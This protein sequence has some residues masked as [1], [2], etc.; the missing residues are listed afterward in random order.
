MKNMWFKKI[1]AVING[2]KKF[3]SLGADWAERLCDLGIDG[4]LLLMFFGLPIFFVG[5]TFQGIAFEKEVYFYFIVLLSLVFWALKS[6]ISGEMKIRKSP[7]DIPLIAFII[8]VFISTVLSVDKWHSFLGSFVDPSRGLVGLMAL[9]VAFYLIFERTRGKKATV[10]IGALI[11]SNF[12]LS[13]WTATQIMDLH[14]P[15]GFLSSIPLNLSDS[16]TDLVSFFS[17]MLPVLVGVFIKANGYQKNRLR[18]IFLLSFLGLSVVLDLFLVFAFYAFLSLAGWIALIVGLAFF[19]IFIISKV[20]R[21]EKQSLIWLPALIFALL[22]ILFAGGKPVNIAR[23]NL[24]AEVSLNYQASKE[25]AKGALGEKLFFGSGPATY[26]YVASRFHPKNLNLNAVY[27][28]RFSQGTGF[29]FESLAT[30]GTLGTVF[31]IVLI[32]SFFGIGTYLITSGKDSDKMYPLALFSAAIVFLGNLLF[33]RTGGPLIISGALIS[34]LAMATMARDGRTKKDVI[35]FSLKASPKFALALAFIFMVVSVSVLGLFIFVGRIFIADIYAGA[36]L[37]NLSGNESV[38]KL[39]KAIEFNGQEGR[40]HT[41]LGQVYLNLA[42]S[43]ATKDEQGRDLSALR[44]N[45]NSSIS[46]ATKGRDL[47]PTDAAAQEVLAQVYEQVG[48]YAPD[49]L[50][51][52]EDAYRKALQME[53]NN[54]NFFLKLGLIKEAQSMTEKDMTEKTNSVR[55]AENLF[56]QS[57]DLKQNFSVGYY[58][59]ALAEEA[60]GEIDRAVENMKTAFLLENGNINFAFNLGRL[61]QARGKG[62]DNVIAESI[63]RQIIGINNKEINAHYNLGFLYEKQKRNDEASVEYRAALELLPDTAEQAR[64]Q[65]QKMIENLKKGV[66]NTPENLKS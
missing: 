46:A 61:Y 25:I 64:E 3:S 19:L 39:T 44:N 30:L 26:D 22:M 62:D 11:I 36:T 65:T 42:V 33:V 58:Q 32:L 7:L 41:R 10:F 59:L 23:I 9:T 57:V 8:V 43:E 6:V 47:M 63:F 28:L 27:N 56:Q 55:E 49:S 52:A 21:L 20:V 1:M 60:L 15:P 54:P 4:S 2:E 17:M 18:R 16:F 5:K 24:P 53:P 13:V 45:L 37:N 34:M 31:L 38:L 14:F 12:I 66:E 50:G 29:V 40:Y 48:V 35:T 51:S